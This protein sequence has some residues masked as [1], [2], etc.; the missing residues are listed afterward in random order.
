MI[1]KFK[2]FQLTV[3]ATIIC[4]ALGG[5]S[6]FLAGFLIFTA[7]VPRTAE[8]LSQNTE[9]IVVLTGGSERLRT[10]LQ[11][12]EAG[13]AEKMFVSGVPD[14]VDVHALLAVV[15]EDSHE[16]HDQ[17]EIGH[18]AR[19]TVGNARETKKW[20]LQQGFKSIRLVTAGYHMVR[21]LREFSRVMPGLEVV[22]Y[23]VF[24]ETVHLDNWWQWP[25]TTALLF[26]EYVK[27]L[28]SYLR[29]AVEL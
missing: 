14:E 6:A 27:F 7:K 22:P 29:A 28:I 1:I 2:R 19:D 26:D 24:P 13:W 3:R 23:P 4:L 20:M 17:V 9:A 10:G 11:L 15:E 8:P 5:L 12:L 16:L 21:S 25:G 18:E